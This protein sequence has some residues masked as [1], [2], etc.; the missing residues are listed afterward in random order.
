MTEPTDK[1][2]GP[3]RPIGLRNRPREK[4][5]VPR[6]RYRL[7]ELEQACGISR[8]AVDRAIKAGTIKT[9][10]KNRIIPA[11]EAQRLMTPR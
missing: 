9:I 4:A 10:G 5:P 11:V 2:A 8:A 3:G 6:L 1:R 7:D